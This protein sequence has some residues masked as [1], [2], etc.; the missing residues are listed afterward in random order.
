MTVTVI[1]GATS[2]GKSGIAMEA[3]LEV[4]NV[5]IIS[6]DAFQVYIGFDIGTAK[7]PIQDRKDVPHHLIDINEPTKAYTAGLFASETERLIGEIVARGKIPL[8]VGGTG[9]YIK[10]LKDG[11]FEPPF[12]DE[13]IRPMIKDRWDSKGLP[14]LYAQLQKLDP[15]YAGRISENDPVRIVRAM[16]VCEGLGMPFTEAHKLYHKPAKYNY[17]IFAPKL[18]RNILYGGINERT[19]IMWEAGWD[20]EVEGLLDKGISEDCPA[21]RAIGYKEIASFLRGEIGKAETVAQIAQETRHFAKRQTTW[22]NSMKEI[23]FYSDKKV[24]LEEVVNNM[25]EP[26]S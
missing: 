19:R 20:K 17:R 16:E 6:A 13:A 1:T 7:T 2:V 5:E 9:L 22:F 12:I 10:T 4:G 18:E 3:A 24:I 11:M 26:R 25:R 23:L 15:V 8:V 21:F 14:A